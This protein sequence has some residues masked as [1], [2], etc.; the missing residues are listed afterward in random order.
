M[1][2]C[3]C[4]NYR[5]LRTLLEN[6]TRQ[7]QKLVSDVKTLQRKLKDAQE[8]ANAVHVLHHVDLDSRRPPFS[9]GAK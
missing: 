5:L 4:S 8:H 1:S 9:G 6:R 3:R 7:N 2:V